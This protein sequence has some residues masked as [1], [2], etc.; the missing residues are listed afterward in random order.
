MTI[1]ELKNYKRILIL[2]YGVEGKATHQFLK[3]FHPEVDI[4]IADQSIDPNY[5]EKQS[6]FDLV[7]KSPGIRKELVTKPYTTAT[8][9]FFANVKGKT[10]G[11]TGTKGK[12]TT[13]SLI[14]H[15][16]KWSGLPAYLVGNIGIPALASLI[17]NNLKRDVYVMELSSYQLADIN[18]SPH[19]SVVINLFPDHMTYHGSVAN[20]YK[21]KLRIVNAVKSNDYYVYNAHFKELVEAAKKTIAQPIPIINEIPFKLPK[22]A[23]LGGHNMENVKAALTVS[24]LFSI[25]DDIVKSALATF[26]PLPHRLESVGIYSDI[27]FFDDAA[28]TTPQSTI[29]AITALSNIGTIMLGG[30]DRGYDFS[31]LAK[32]ICAAEIANVIL[33]PDAGPKIK[34]AIEDVCS[35]KINFYETD[36]MREAVAYAYQ[37]TEKGKICLL[38]TACPSYTLWQNFSEKG[39]QF[40]EFVK[41]QGK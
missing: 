5:L 19:I 36:S 25:K 35:D 11:V 16:L 14:H 17:K 2:G 8:N 3:R 20:Y 22:V 33:F 40:Q 31:D 26:K 41:S 9:I 18:Y 7:I 12:S 39:N 37:N 1:A 6:Y 23:L 10:I 15:I 38:S 4:G 32:K 24:K 28:S 34:Q 21:A 30:Q 13:V 29:V 27:V